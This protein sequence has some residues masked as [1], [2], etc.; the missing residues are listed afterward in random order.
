[1]HRAQRD[2][3]RVA[4]ATYALV[5]RAWRNLRIWFGIAAG[6]AAIGC[7]SSARPEGNVSYTPVVGAE[8]KLGPGDKLL[9]TVF[10]EPQLSGEFLVSNS[11]AIAMPRVGE[12]RAGG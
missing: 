11:G 1:M 10:N 5:S 2:I 6:A 4:G 12:I 7:Q 9:V 8:Y 3:D